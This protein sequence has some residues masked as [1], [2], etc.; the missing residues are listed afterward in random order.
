MKKDI[1]MS[2]LRRPI[3]EGDPADDSRAFR[4]SLGQFATGVTVMTA[5]DGQRLVGMSVNSFSAL[6]L[7]PPLILW[8]IRRESASWSVFERAGHFAVNV[9]AASQVELSNRFASSSADKFVGID[10]LPD[11]QGAPL[12]PGVIAHM[13][14][15]LH[16]VVDGGDHLV[17]IGRVQ[18]FARFDGEP[19]VFTQGRYA[20]TQE[21][22]DALQMQATMNPIKPEVAQDVSSGTILRLLHF[23]SQRMSQAFLGHRIAQ[24]LSV[25]QFRIFGWL[26]TGAYSADALKRLA[27]LGS[28]DADDTLAA[29]LEQGS[30]RQDD[31][32]A[33][34]LTALGHERAQAIVR[35]VE[36]FES[37]LMQGVPAEDLAAT[38]RVLGLLAQRTGAAP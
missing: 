19:L 14:C 7:E 9:L 26:R 13:E 17:L 36:A 2:A 21:H 1:P 35:H 16:Q 4:R 29:M 23:T 18:R 8:S 12:L 6:S 37:E 22:P 27:F 38:R 24:G 5:S 3:E 33:F 20:V 31:S 30:L 28:R 15:A 34:H 32:G 10:W 11:P 25:A